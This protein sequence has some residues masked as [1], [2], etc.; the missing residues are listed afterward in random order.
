MADLKDTTEDLGLAVAT[1][2]SDGKY[3]QR[4]GD[5]NSAIYMGHDKDGRIQVVDQWPYNAEHNSP[6]LHPIGNYGPS[7][8][9]SQGHHHTNENNAYYYHVI[10]VK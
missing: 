3:R 9:D 10:I 2:G 7:G 4:D 8:I 6:F 5:Q 1:F